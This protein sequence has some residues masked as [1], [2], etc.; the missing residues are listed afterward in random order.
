VEKVSPT[1]FPRRPRQPRQGDLRS[2]CACSV[3]GYTAQCSAWLYCGYDYGKTMYCFCSL[4]GM[5]ETRPLLSS[6]T[7]ENNRAWYLTISHYIPVDWPV[8][9]PSCDSPISTITQDRD[10]RTTPPL[11]L[12]ELNS[13]NHVQSRRSADVQTLF[14]EKTIDHLDGFGIGNVESS[15]GV[16][17][18]KGKVFWSRRLLWWSF[19][20]ALGSVRDAQAG[21]LRE[22]S[23][24]L[25]DIATVRTLPPR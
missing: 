2:G 9:H 15:G 4:S 8:V 19:L 14:V 21:S 25:V 3:H 23:A 10:D 17:L 11:F 20:S 7:L 24:L 1:L 6:Q 16:S 18:M 5:A 22:P 12:G 13:S